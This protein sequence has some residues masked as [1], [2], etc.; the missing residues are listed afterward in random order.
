[1]KKFAKKILLYTILLLGAAYV[2]EAYIDNELKHVYDDTYGDWNRIFNGEINAD[3]IILGSSRAWVQ[4]NTQLIEDETGLSC[5]NL[6]IDGASLTIQQTRWDSYIEHNSPPKILI[7]DIDLLAYGSSNKQNIY[8]KHQY[9]PYL[10]KNTISTHL[11]KL[12]PL[13]KYEA[14]I[15]LLKYRG[16]KEHVEDYLFSNKKHHQTKYKGFR[17]QEKEWDNSQLENLS[18]KGEHIIKSEDQLKIGERIINNLSQTCKNTN[19]QLFLVHSPMYIDALPLLPQQSEFIVIVKHLKEKVN[20]SFLNYATTEISYHSKYFY[21]ATH[22]NLEG[23]NL[24]TKILIRDL[25]NEL[26]NDSIA[27]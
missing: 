12:D 3:I 18:K 13:I 19:T 27:K 23:A 1:M 16:Y 7:Q 4:Y 2:L 20:C 25:V 10:K 8:Q 24:F 5:Y 9:L 14:Y 26:K 21:N 15:P 17:G 6:G 11:S 22:L